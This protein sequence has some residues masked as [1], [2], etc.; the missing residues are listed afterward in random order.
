MSAM[1]EEKNRKQREYR[2]KNNDACTARYEKTLKGHLI[3]TYRNMQSRVTGVQK[4]KAHLY[5][6]LDLLDR[7][8]FYEWAL[9]NA[10]YLRLHEEWTAQGF[11]RTLTPSIDRIRSSEGYV[12][13]NMQWLTH[14]ENSRKG[15][16]SRFGT[17]GVH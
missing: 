14:S 13:D 11:P 17:G 8:D 12:L 5:E 9:N 3:R 15:C 4:K 2:R 16:H 7:E 10:T 1:R 6:G